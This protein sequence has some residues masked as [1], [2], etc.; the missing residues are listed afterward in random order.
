VD[1]LR[2]IRCFAL[3]AERLSFSRAAAEL[4]VSQPAT[5]QA[6]GRLERGLGVRLFERT[7]REVRL[8]AAGKAL[9]PYAEEL[10]DAATAFGAEAARQAAPTITLAY[11]PLVGA[12]AARVARRLATRTTAVEVDLRPAGW[13]AATAALAD[14]EVPAAILSAPFPTGF[15]TT[16]RFQVTVGHLAVPAGDPLSAATRVQPEQL[17]RYRILMPRNRPPGSMWA[18]LAARLTG[19]HQYRVIGADIDDFAAMLDLVAA[20]LGLLPAPELL[21]RAIRRPDVHFVPLDAGELRLLYGLAWSPEH[22]SAELMALVQT[23]HEA[24]RSR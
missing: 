18:R 5:S 9:L 16:A 1:S 15:A 14:G 23:V 13:G 20:G 17:S 3:V 2:D 10:L 6:V 22:A 8:T 19:P 24:L 7:S 4:G 11:P 21:V 12:L